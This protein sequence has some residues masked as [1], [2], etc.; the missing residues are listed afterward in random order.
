M[1][2]KKVFYKNILPLIT[3]GNYACM[4]CFVFLIALYSNIK[5]FLD[6]DNT[7]EQ[8]NS[9]DESLFLISSFKWL[10]YYAV[11]KDFYPNLFLYK[12]SFCLFFFL[13]S[14]SRS[15][16]QNSDFYCTTCRNLDELASIY[17][18]DMCVCLLRINH[19]VVDLGG[20]LLS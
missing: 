5:L 13:C 17:Q 10:I 8:N 19:A 7:L 2:D 4:S 16:E 20:C 18:V 14:I 9:Y 11:L 3:T 15:I 12:F 6:H 1:E